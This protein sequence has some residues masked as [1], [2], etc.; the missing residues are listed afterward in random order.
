MQYDLLYHI[1]KEEKRPSPE[2]VLWKRSS[3][4]SKNRSAL[5]DFLKRIFQI[6]ISFMVYPTQT[7]LNNNDILIHFI[8]FNKIFE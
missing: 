7:R 2:G 5:L 3:K 8:E 6:N 4:I 1:S